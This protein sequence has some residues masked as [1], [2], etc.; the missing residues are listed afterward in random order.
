MRN[1]GYYI[2]RNLMTYMGQGHCYVA[3]IRRLRW[4]EHI[5]RMADNLYRILVGD[6][7]KRPAR[8]PKRMRENYI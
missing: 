1:L 2:I 5:D 6:L 8:R 4:T 3:E 7:I